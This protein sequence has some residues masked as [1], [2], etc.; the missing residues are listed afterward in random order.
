MDNPLLKVHGI[1]Q[2]AID[3]M[4]SSSREWELKY[5]QRVSVYDKSSG[6]LCA[7][8][9]LTVQSESYEG[10]YCDEVVKDPVLPRMFGRYMEMEAEVRSKH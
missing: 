7:G 3:G 10:P 2:G 8:F 5:R 6:E 4:F 1:T 9:I